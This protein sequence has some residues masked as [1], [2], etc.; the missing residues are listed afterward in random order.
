M[1]EVKIEITDDML[2][3]CNGCGCRRHS[4]MNSQHKWCC[5]QEEE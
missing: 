2:I 1:A 5:Q 3:E 4:C